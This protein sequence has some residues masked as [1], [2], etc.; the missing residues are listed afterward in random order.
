[1][2]EHCRAQSSLLRPM[3]WGA[4]QRMHA[5]EAKEVP[6]DCAGQHPRE[7]KANYLSRRG[8]L[9]CGLML[10]RCGV[11]PTRNT[12]IP[13]LRSI[14]DATWPSGAY[15]GVPCEASPSP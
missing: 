8:W 6:Y 2:H 13:H 5:A 9:K 1:M 3:G 15:G 7:R 14:Q 12:P 10:G 11:A 4:P